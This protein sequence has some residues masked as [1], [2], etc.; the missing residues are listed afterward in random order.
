MQVILK[1]LVNPTWMACIEWN[2]FGIKNQ[3]NRDDYVMLLIQKLFLPGASGL[4]LGS[5][6][7]LITGRSETI[8]AHNSIKNPNNN[9]NNVIIIPRRRCEIDLGSVFFGGF[10]KSRNI[11]FE[12]SFFC[13]FLKNINTKT[14]R[15]IYTLFDNN[16]FEYG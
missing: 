16:L 14:R 13:F 6:V 5:K 2:G 11:F 10:I 12:L 9:N 3:K 7:V 15:Y 1:S 4:S 8:L